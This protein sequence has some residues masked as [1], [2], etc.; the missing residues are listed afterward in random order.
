MHSSARQEA[1]SNPVHVRT[2]TRERYHA[3]RYACVLISTVKAF[4][5]EKIRQRL[6]AIGS[7]AELHKHVEPKILPPSVGGSGCGNGNGSA[8]ATTSFEE[9]L[10]IVS[11]TVAAPPPCGAGGREQ[12]LRTSNPGALIVQSVELQ[13]T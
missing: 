1:C 10:K 4:M 9:C 7:V 8:E 5:P 11:A 3:H 2:C 6:H 12:Q 13:H